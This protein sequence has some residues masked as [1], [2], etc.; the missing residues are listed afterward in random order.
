MYTPCYE[1][2]DNTVLLHSIYFCGI[3]KLCFV[4]QSKKTK[5]EFNNSIT[6]LI[7]VIISIFTELRIV[8]GIEVPRTSIY[9]NCQS[10]LC[11]MD[12]IEHVLQN[13]LRYNAISICMPGVH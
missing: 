9:N 7:T 10:Q 8:R 12:L 6:V 3:F 2:V 1:D 4:F 13:I 11:A 5:K